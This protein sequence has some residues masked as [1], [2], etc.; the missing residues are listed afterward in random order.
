MRIKLSDTW[1]GMTHHEDVAAVKDSFK[2]I[3]EK[4][5]YKAELLLIL[6]Y[7]G[8]TGERGSLRCSK[9]C[10]PL[11]GEQQATLM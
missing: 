1:Y 2:K 5:A 10:T 4:G 11:R 6:W 9:L 7:T 8:A 3:L